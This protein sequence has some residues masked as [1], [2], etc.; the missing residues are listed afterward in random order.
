M[1]RVR[2]GSDGYLRGVDIVCGDAH[3]CG[4]AV[5][6]RV[7][8]RL[9][10]KTVAA[11][12]VRAYPERRCVCGSIYRAGHSDVGSKSRL[13]AHQTGKSRETRKDKTPLATAGRAKLRQ[14]KQHELL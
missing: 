2:P 10:S 13:R 7:A 12:V 3:R 11:D 1:N 6:D 5:V 9:R 4:G 14:R 8:E